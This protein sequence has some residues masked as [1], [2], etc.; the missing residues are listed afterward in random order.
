MKRLKYM[1]FISFVKLDGTKEEVELCCANKAAWTKKLAK[2]H[3]FFCKHR[4]DG[5]ILSYEINGICLKG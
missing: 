1:I 5:K 3:D 4:K 2:E